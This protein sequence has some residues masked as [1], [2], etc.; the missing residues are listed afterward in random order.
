MWLNLKGDQS[1]LN[2][3]KAQHTV[4]ALEIHFTVIISIQIIILYTS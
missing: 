2:G 3:Y 4:Y 1:T